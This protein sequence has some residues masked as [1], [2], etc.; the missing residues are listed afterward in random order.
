MQ[1]VRSPCEGLS[2]L[3]DPSPWFRQRLDRV[4]F[5]PLTRYPGI[6]A[7]LRAVFCGS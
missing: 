1:R 3:L 4:G 2:S 6:R 5:R 7:L